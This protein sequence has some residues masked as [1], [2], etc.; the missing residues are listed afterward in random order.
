MTRLAYDFAPRHRDVAIAFSRAAIAS[1]PDRLFDNE[2]LL[3]V[4]RAVGAELEKTNGAC[5]ARSRA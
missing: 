5:A 4:I 1:H 3:D 2:M